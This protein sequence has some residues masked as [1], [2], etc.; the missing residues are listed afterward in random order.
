M[1][2]VIRETGPELWA[3]YEQVEVELAGVD[4]EA[5]RNA[6]HKAAGTFLLT[7]QLACAA[8][9]AERKIY[10]SGKTRDGRPLFASSTRR[11]SRC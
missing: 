5:E 8:P 7:V 3:R 1:A 2:K 10:R 6:A 11:S 4:S 9:E